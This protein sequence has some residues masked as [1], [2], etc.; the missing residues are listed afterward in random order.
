MDPGHSSFGPFY[1]VEAAWARGFTSLPVQPLPLSPYRFVGKIQR[2]Q[3]LALDLTDTTFR[4]VFAEFD[5]LL[6]KA[7]AFAPIV[8]MVRERGASRIR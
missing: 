7:Y 2:G 4:V 1:P 5:F 8:Y 6:G 3:G